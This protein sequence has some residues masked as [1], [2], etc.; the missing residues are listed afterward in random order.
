M[1]NL[2]HEPVHVDQIGLQANLP[3]EE[4][5]A[6]LALMELKGMVRRVGEMRYVAVR[7]VKSAYN[8]KEDE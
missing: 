2:S 8:V 4:I 1:T 6:A 3:I 5:S 7:E